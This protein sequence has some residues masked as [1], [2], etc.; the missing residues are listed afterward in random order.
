[1]YKDKTDEWVHQ[2]SGMHQYHMWVALSG[3]GFGVNL[4]HYNPL[5]DAEVRETWGLPE[6]W[7][8]RAQMVFGEPDEGSD[9][10]P[11]EQ[12]TSAEERVQ[13]FGT[14]E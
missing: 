1:M 4:Q 2:T 3:L 11:K 12:K 9:P 10:G 14:K 6:H 5:I 13:I 8:L 7:A